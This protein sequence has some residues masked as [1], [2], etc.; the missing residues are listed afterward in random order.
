[1]KYFTFK[2]GTPKLRNGT[3]L[4]ETKKKKRK[5]QRNIEKKKEEKKEEGFVCSLN[6]RWKIGKNRSIESS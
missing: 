3:D 5:A 1:M 2:H 4:K 6:Y